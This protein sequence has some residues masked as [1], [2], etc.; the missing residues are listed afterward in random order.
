MTVIY[1]GA[2]YD[3]ETKVD[4]DTMEGN[5]SGSAASGAFKGTRQP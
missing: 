4:G 5:Y 1:D 3:V 2:P